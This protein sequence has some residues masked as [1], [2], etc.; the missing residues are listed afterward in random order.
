MRSALCLLAV[1]AFACKSEP[2]KPKEVSFSRDIEPVLDKQCASANGCHGPKPT[3][4]VDLNLSAGRS[5][6]ELVGMASET[7]PGALR[8]Q[9]GD[10]ANS[11]I[12]N[13]LSGK[14]GP[15]EGKTMPLDPETGVSPDRSPLP[16]RFLKDV[17][18]P[19]IAQGAQKN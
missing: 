13:K 19:W 17:L 18:E 7:R 3:H 4:S 6:D 15:K 10:V 5:W 9:P 12:I 1:F 2:P 14:L 16:D 11:F 8:V